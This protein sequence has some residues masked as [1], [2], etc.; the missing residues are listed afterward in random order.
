MLDIKFI[1]EHT[2]ELKEAVK[3]KGIKL[4]LDE[5]LEVDKERVALTREA[6]LFN[7]SKNELSDRISKAKDETERKALI[8]EGRG[9]KEPDLKNLDGVKKRFDELMAKVPTIPS[10]DT[11]VGRDESGNK[12]IFRW[13]EPK[14]FDFEPKN[15]IELGKALDILDFDRG[16]KV[17]GFRGYY[18]KNDGVLLTIGL[19]M[20]ALN[21]MVSR[22]FT[23]MIPPT[24]VKQ[25]ALFGSGYFKGLE[26]DPN[27]DEIYQVATSD[28]EATGEISKDKKFLVGTAEPSLLAYYAGEV[29]EGKN[30]PVKLCG[31]SQCYRS[32]IGSY[33]KDV[34]GL[35]RV[36][37]FM[38]VEQVAIVEAN[39]EEANKLQDEMTSISGEMHEELGLTYRR[40]QI[41]TGD[42]SPGKYRA[43]D[44]EAWL[45]GMKRWAET[46]SASN[47]LDW[48]SRRLNI[49]YVDGPEERKYVYM[50]NNTALPSPRVLIAILEN[51]QTKDGDIVVPEVL[52]GYLGKE[53]IKK[54]R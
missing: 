42:M 31:Y 13:G 51:Y 29:L 30:L 12:E 3:N 41:C 7:R 50:L 40:L 36:H 33:S 43:F 11:P 6:E 32:E 23:P 37:E 8:Q 27:I 15:H 4:D 5:L 22:G 24:L 38:K 17:G 26:Y 46:G 19:M 18:L 53:L 52:R 2:A 20:Y 21:K 48:Q 49:K 44:L 34:K 28:K 1:R 16:G 35:Y 45:P 39:I 25:F 9:L 54:P 14:E 47:F 10:P